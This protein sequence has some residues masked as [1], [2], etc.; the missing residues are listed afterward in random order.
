MKASRALGVTLG[1]I[2]SIGGYLDVGAIATTA[3]AGALF[4]FRQ[5]WVVALGTLCAIFLVEMSGRFAAVSKHTIRGAM[6]E[7]LGPNFFVV[8][9]LMSVI[10]NVLVIA[11]EI[12]GVALALQ[13]VTGVHFRWWAAPVA[14]LVWL[15]LW[16]GTFGMLEK[17]IAMLGLVTL[18]FVVGAV[19]THPPLGELAEGLLPRGPGPGDG[20]RYWF[21]AVSILGAIISPYLFYFYSSGAVEDRWDESHIGSN[22]IVATAGMGFGSIVAVG[23]LVTSAMVLMPRGIT[24]DRYE[25]VAEI[26]VPPLGQAGIYLFAASLGIAC[27]GAAL[28]A[29]LSTAYELA[30]GFGWNW[31]E[32]LRPNQ[33]SRFALAYTVVLAVAVIPALIGVDPLKLTIFSMALTALILPPVVL[34]FLILM[35]DRR[36]L[37]SHQNGYVSNAV[38]VAIIALTFVLAVV[39]IP[40][41]IVGG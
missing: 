30:Q 22:R 8:T 32:S 38:V 10:V 5:L 21:V 29:S 11:S 20:P 31:G 39:A 36:Y 34:P 18:A 41:Q 24:V 19:R 37:G 6:R 28:E 2:T 33:A 3:Q 1:I 40:L 9:L 16:K 15:L 12:G 23:V 14:L 35:N 26:L 7:K 25:D 27:L 17:G 13:L 4:G